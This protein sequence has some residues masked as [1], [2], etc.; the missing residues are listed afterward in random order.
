MRTMRKTQRKTSGN[1]TQEL[2]RECG[3]CQSSQVPGK[4]SK[5]T[6]TSQSW[7]NTINIPHLHPTVIPLTTIFP[8]NMATCIH[9]ANSWNPTPF[10]PTPNSNDTMSNIPNKS[11]MTSNQNSDSTPENTRTEGAEPALTVVVVNSVATLSN[12][13]SVDSS[14][15]TPTHSPTP[16][17]KSASTITNSNKT[18]LLHHNSQRKLPYTWPNVTKQT[19]PT[20]TS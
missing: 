18:H 20:S 19:L 11:T 1:R 17:W 12:G 13:M 14:K 4:L 6:I 10:P 8:R 15:H 2:P 7:T 9:P 16:L 5:K 3:D